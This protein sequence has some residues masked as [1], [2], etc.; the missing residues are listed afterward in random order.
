MNATANAEAVQIL[1]FENRGFPIQTARG[2]L[3]VVPTIQPNSNEEPQI[4]A[5][6][7]KAETAE[8]KGGQGDD[9]EDCQKCN[10]DVDVSAT[11]KCNH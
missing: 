2:T 6:A 5:K 3:P 8:K 10:K 4:M 1:S 11:P 9:H 7:V